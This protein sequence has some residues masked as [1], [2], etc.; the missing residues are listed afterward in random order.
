M[1]KYHVMTRGFPTREVVAE[2]AGKA[3][4]RQFRALQEAGYYRGSSFMDRKTARNRFFID[5]KI[6]AQGPTDETEYRSTE[7]VGTMN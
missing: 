1:R 4:A 5:T 2:N 3:K 6:K 7:I